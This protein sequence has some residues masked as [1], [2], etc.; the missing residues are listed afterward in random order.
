MIMNTE[1]SKS[2][3][4]QCQEIVPGGVNSN[5]RAPIYFDKA[6]GS[7]LWDVDGNEYV[8][9]VVNNGACILGHGDPDIEAEVTK[10]VKQGL[11]SSLETPLSLQVCRQLHDLIP[12]AEQARLANTGTEAVMKALMMARAFTG[13]EKIIKIEIA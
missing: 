11:T 4:N 12:S 8:D 9:C 3:F 2:L 1:K 5:F 6:Q 7:R 13:R 10:A